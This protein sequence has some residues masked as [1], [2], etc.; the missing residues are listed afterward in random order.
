MKTMRRFVT[1]ARLHRALDEVEAWAGYEIKAAPMP[2]HHRR[3]S[4]CTMH[5]SPYSNE[6]ELLFIP[7]EPQSQA[8]Y[9]HELNHAVL[10][11]AGG[12]CE[13]NSTPIPF[14]ELLEFEPI[15]LAWN[16]VTHLPLWELTRDMGFDESEDY[17]PL[18]QGMIDMVSQN[19]LYFDAPPE[20]MIPLQSVALAF[21]LAAPGTREKRAQIRTV[22]TEMT[23]QALESANAILSDFEKLSLLS[24]QG[25][26]AA[27]GQL[28][29]IIK[30]PIER[31]QFSFLDRTDP[32]F[33][34]R[35]LEVAK[36]SD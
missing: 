33:R 24:E 7:E 34:S 2:H 19:R 35:I 9:C 5:I 15:Y 30:P 17:L 26:Q 10:W 36:L 27:L 1:D 4:R 12:P 31:L 28:F 3:K 22:A 18:V 14:R 20:L 8:T 21:A 13:C 25:C 6:F 32:N 11:I 16:L 23:P 29:G